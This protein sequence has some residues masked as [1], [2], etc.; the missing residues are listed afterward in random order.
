M[1]SKKGRTKTVGVGRAAAAAAGGGAEIGVAPCG[2][3]AGTVAIAGL[4]LHQGD[5]WLQKR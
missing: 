5:A 3:W 2:A 1:S 4:P